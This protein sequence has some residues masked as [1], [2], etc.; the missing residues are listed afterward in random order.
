M[1]TEETKADD[2]EIGTCALIFLRDFEVLA[3]LD[4]KL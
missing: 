3:F 2:M 4:K 1:D